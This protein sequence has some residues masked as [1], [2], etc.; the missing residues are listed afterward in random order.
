MGIWASIKLWFSLLF[1][2]CC[3]K[4]PIA[5]TT[6]RTIPN[7]VMTEKTG[8]KYLVV[9][10]HGFLGSH[11]VE[12][13]L[14]R[15]ET[16]I[17]I[18]D[19]A[20]SRLFQNEQEKGIV[21]FIRG[22]VRRVED[23][24]ASAVGCETVF[25]CAGIVNL[26]ARLP[27]QLDR[28]FTINLVGTQNVLEACSKNGVKQ[29][30]HAS[31][32]LVVVPRNVLENPV[33]NMTE[34]NITYPTPPYINHYIYSK[35]LAEKAV[36]SANAKRELATACL[37]PGRIF[38]PRDTT[39]AGRIC[40]GEPLVSDV[41]KMDFVYV[42]NV[43]HAFFCLEKSMTSPAV[44]ASGKAYFITNRQPCSILEMYEMF[45]RKTGHK[46]VQIPMFLASLCCSLSEWVCYL[47]RAKISLGLADFYT[48]PV[49]T[50]TCAEIY[51]NDSLSQRAL[52]YSPI[53]TLE[54]GVDITADYFI[55]RSK[56]K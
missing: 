55:A 47:T 27:F 11:V 56:S 42:E 33:R 20:A 28:I 19:R 40:K 45:N 34:D 54:E 53:Y 14:A 50:L 16:H 41:G 32:C 29:L 44:P 12:A 37:R 17:T 4:R 38:G 9:G 26:W 8:K 25:N 22:D 6:H 5:P 2:F 15:G 10:G 51:V 3:R 46:L 35:I 23:V 30:L 43:V 48:P 52:N 21:K 24:V 31:S 7:R 1:L 13:L 49:L 39:S 18:F 36:L